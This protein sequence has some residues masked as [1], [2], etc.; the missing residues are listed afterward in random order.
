MTTPDATRIDAMLRE[1]FA[2]RYLGGMLPT[3]EGL[4]VFAEANPAALKPEPLP[5]YLNPAVRD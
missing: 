5:L 4:R 3:A 2:E 1:T